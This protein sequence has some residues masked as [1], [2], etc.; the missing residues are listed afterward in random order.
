MNLKKSIIWI[1]VLI[2]LVTFALDA[3]AAITS[4]RIVDMNGSTLFLNYDDNTT[5]YADISIE[6]PE[7][8]LELCADTSAELLNNYVTWNY[9]VLDL[10]K[11]VSIMPAQIT[12]VN[13]SNCTIVNIDLS[14]GKAYY[15]AVL[16]VALSTS[17]D[18]SSAAF[19]DMDMTTAYLK[20]NYTFTVYDDG[21]SFINVT[22]TQALD[23][24]LNPMGT[25]YDY[26][27]VGILEDGILME[28]YITSINETIIFN[29]YGNNYTFNIN[30][31]LF[32]GDFSPPMLENLV[33]D[34]NQTGLLPT[35]PIDFDVEDN[36]GVNISTL[37]VWVNGVPTNISGTILINSNNPLNNLSYHFNYIHNG[38]FPN[39]AYVY[40]DVY[41]CDLKNNCL[42]DTYWFYVGTTPTEPP[43]GGRKRTPPDSIDPPSQMVPEPLPEEI[44]EAPSIYIYRVDVDGDIVAEDHEIIDT[45]LWMSNSSHSITV[46]FVNDG[47]IPLE[48]IR[49]SVSS[50]GSITITEIDPLSIGSLAIGQNGKFDVDIEAGVLSN[51]F[52]IDFDV[53]AKGASDS[54]SIPI[55]VLPFRL[56][57]LEFIQLPFFLYPLIFLPLLLLFLR[58]LALNERVRDLIG[59]IISIFYAV[60]ISDEAMLRRLIKEKKIEEYRKIY[61]PHSTYVR[62][63]S[64]KNLVPIVVFVKDVWQVSTMK[65]K[66]KI[67]DEMAHLLYFAAKRNKVKFLTEK[68]VHE[69]IKKDFKHVIFINPFEAIKKEI[70]KIEKEAVNEIHKI[71]DE[72]KHIEQVAATEIKKDVQV[73]KKDVHIA[74]EKIGQFMHIRKS[75][76]LEDYVNHAVGRGVPD[77]EIKEKMLKTGWT[78]REVDHYLKNARR[79]N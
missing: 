45:P 46:R 76:H 13:A 7:A 42:N 9:K 6:N 36:I 34:R 69:G 31:L 48:N 57:P 77:E 19:F 27:I 15:P 32:P 78:E 54:I 35:T 52:M 16:S 22:I 11:S 51:S 64:V 72:A 65:S 1:F 18:M 66:Y 28:S 79:H 23:D 2:L 33:P 59:N 44:I 67:D 53:D 41:V 70:Q 50:P 4:A 71:E 12:A 26:L 30:G 55:D 38:S 58:L 39:E 73:I 25:D 5:S 24:F 3:S 17:S 49:L 10:N 14:R 43:L 40:V 74:E 62:Y 63:Q 61:V 37:K 60:A 21:L 56:Q 75:K 47:N 8:L 29:K 68:E 20:G